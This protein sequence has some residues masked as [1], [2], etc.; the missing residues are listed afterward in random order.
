M[1]SQQQSK[2]GD[3]LRIHDYHTAG[4]K[5]IIKEYLNNLP[6]DERVQGYAIRQRIV[7]KGFII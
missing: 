5:N 2:G 4:G 3:V 7:V 6:E 1:K